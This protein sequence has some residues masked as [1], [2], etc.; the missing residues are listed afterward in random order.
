[1]SKKLFY[2]LPRILSVLFILF[3]SL[4]ALDAF[5]DPQ[6]YIAFPIHLIPTFILLFLTLIA[7]KRPKFGGLV[8]CLFGLLSYFIFHT[9]ILT[10]PVLFIGIF[11]FLANNTG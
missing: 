9:L 8:F 5:D 1:M 2:W 7:W 10:L 4:F 6:W 11:Y 3:I